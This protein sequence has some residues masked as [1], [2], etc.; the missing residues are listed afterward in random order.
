MSRF[1]ILAQL[2]VFKFHTS[3]LVCCDSTCLTP[4]PHSSYSFRIFGF[5]KHYTDVRNMSRQQRQKVLGKAWSVPVIRHLFAPLK[6]YFACEELPAL[7]TSTNTST[8]PRM[9]PDPQQL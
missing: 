3:A 5:P 7:T 8:S 4:I 9:R 1:E 6:D 2:C